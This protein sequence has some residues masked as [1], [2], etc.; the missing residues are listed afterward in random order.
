MFSTK[1]SARL[2]L[3]HST[4]VMAERIIYVYIYYAILYIYKYTKQLLKIEKWK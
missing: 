1:I 4:I 3:L 2:N